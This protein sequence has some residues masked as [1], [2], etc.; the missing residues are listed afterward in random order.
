[1]DSVKKPRVIDVY[2]S[3]S[4]DGFCYDALDALTA[5]LDIV[6]QFDRLLADNPT[7]KMSRIDHVR[8]VRLIALQECGQL[9]TYFDPHTDATLTERHKACLKVVNEGA[10]R[11]VDIEVP[12]EIDNEDDPLVVGLVQ[13]LCTFVRSL[14]T[15]LRVDDAKE[16][17]SVVKEYCRG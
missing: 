2:D 6:D 8:A 10:D 17:A 16:R 12:A 13:E 1:M 5:S 4:L 15:A 9:Q 7:H 11:L 3:L 14:Y